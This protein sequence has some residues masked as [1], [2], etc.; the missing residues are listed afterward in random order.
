MKT[1]FAVFVT[2]TIVVMVM[3]F[4]ASLVEGK[5]FEKTQLANGTVPCAVEEP[6][7][8]IVRLDQT[9]DKLCIPIGARCASECDKDRKCSNYNY[10]TTDRSCQLFHHTPRNC[11]VIRGCF[12]VQVS[13]PFIKQSRLCKLDHIKKSLSL[14]K[15]RTTLVLSYLSIISDAYIFTFF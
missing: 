2:M 3:S 11:S 5:S 7:S 10:R 8:S 4:E 13:Q 9:E 1:Q 15:S 12:H 14:V 6:S